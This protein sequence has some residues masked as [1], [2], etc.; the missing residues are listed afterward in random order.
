MLGDLVGEVV[1]WVFGEIFGGVLELIWP[2]RLSGFAVFVVW[3]AIGGI[4][5]AV[6]RWW[7]ADPSDLRTRVAVLTW[8]FLPGIGIALTLTYDAG[9]QQRKELPRTAAGAGVLRKQRLRGRRPG[10][11]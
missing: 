4:V 7:Q 9:L 5:W 1:G 2:K 11:W 10:A 6:S 3:L 8:L